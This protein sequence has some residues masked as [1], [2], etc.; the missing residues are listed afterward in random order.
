L[1]AI[2]SGR[3]L[4]AMTGTR[5][6]TWRFAPAAFL[7]SLLATMGAPSPTSALICAREWGDDTLAGARQ[8]V[9]D[10]A[11][12]EGLVVGTIVATERKDD[13]WRTPVLV[14]EP[15]V[16]FAGDLPDTLRAEIGGHGP[17]MTFAEGGTYFLALTRETAT[18][19]WFVHPCGPNM[20]ITRPD[21]LAQLRA[22]GD[23]EV[24]VSEPSIPEAG[25]PVVARVGAALVAALTAGW[26]LRRSRA[27]SAAIG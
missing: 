1:T 8:A 16:V 14:V 12:W 6:R 10:P 22:I 17:D 19:A 9:T 24:L 3:T 15:N 25:L 11:R 27:V 4:A 2:G 21:Q 13:Y 5:A 26:L 23:R 20:A 18:G 7:L